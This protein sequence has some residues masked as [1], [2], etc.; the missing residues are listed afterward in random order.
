MDFV[1]LPP[2]AGVPARLLGLDLVERARRMLRAAGLTQSGGG[3]TADMVMFPAEIAGPAAVG[4][5][6]AQARPPAGGVLAIGAGEG[7]PILVASG[8]VRGAPPPPSDTRPLAAPAIV[9]RADN[10]REARRFMLRCLR[11]PVDGLISRTINRPISLAMSS[12][13]VETPITPNQLTIL[14]F[15]V[16][17][18]AAALMTQGHFFLGACVMQFSSILDGCDGEVA[19]LKYQSSRLGGWL[20]TILDDVSN[21]IFLL[22]TAWGVY[23]HE[24]TGLLRTLVLAAAI[25]AFVLG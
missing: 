13:F 18:V 16:A 2:P 6:V 7:R 24:A 12:L 4:K 15:V 22:S 5:E 1:V 10:V 21:Q 9:V 14:T 23:H 25:G 8:S 11:K 17:L 20:D 3:G 19:R